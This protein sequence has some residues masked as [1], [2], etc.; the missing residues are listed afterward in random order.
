[1]L[2][3]ILLYIILCIAS[4]GTGRLYLYLIR[5]G[6]LFDFIQPLLADLKRENTF[7]FK[8]LGGC[9]VCSRQ[10]FT[11]LSYILLLAV[12]PSIF[13]NYNVFIGIGFHIVLFCFYG[14]LAFYFDSLIHNQA[15]SGPEIKSQSLEL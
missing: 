1:M 6:N 8:S 14:G 9:D 7:L 15:G 11:E 10:R 13:N 3:F 2:E 5:P 4:V 12:A